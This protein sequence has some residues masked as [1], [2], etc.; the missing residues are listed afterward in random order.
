MAHHLIVKHAL[1]KQHSD[2][3]AAHSTLE[4]NDEKQVPE[5]L[6]RLPVESVEHEAKG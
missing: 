5:T 2:S 3:L 1:L 6:V 4:G